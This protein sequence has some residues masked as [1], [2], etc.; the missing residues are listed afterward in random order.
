MFNRVQLRSVK[1]PSPESTAGKPGL[2]PELRSYQGTESLCGLTMRLRD[3]QIKNTLEIRDIQKNM[4]VVVGYDWLS[5]AYTC[6]VTAANERSLR[7]APLA[8]RTRSPYQVCACMRVCVRE[9]YLWL[10]SMVAR[11][12]SGCDAAVPV[13]W[14]EKRRCTIA[15]GKKASC[16]LTTLGMLMESSVRTGGK[17]FSFKLPRVKHKTEK[18]K[19]VPDSLRR[20]HRCD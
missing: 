6:I 16:S 3:C 14:L 1:S 7:A 15:P 4:T 13:A 17:G 10:G 8:A 9:G 19:Q 18:Q 20:P 2:S 5:K 12:A 11:G